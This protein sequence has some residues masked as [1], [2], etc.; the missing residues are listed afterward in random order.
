[1]PPPAPA[2]R[3]PVESRLRPP[4]RPRR[5]RHGRT[6][7]NESCLPPPDSYR[8]DQSRLVHQGVRS[9]TR[10]GSVTGRVLLSDINPHHHRVVRRAGPT[11]APP[12][13]D[14]NGCRPLNVTWPRETDPVDT[15]PPVQGPVG[16]SVLAGS[17]SRTLPNSR[18]GRVRSAPAYRFGTGGRAGA[19]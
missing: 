19:I 3:R 9:K 11:L 10:P 15:R 16:I 7:T 13:I 8:A 2:G 5:G 18:T 4:Q 1:T 17:S 12:S 6:S 14:L